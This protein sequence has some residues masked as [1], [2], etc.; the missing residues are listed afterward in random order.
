[1]SPSTRR[2]GGLGALPYTRE[3][4]AA[5]GH[6]AKLEIILPAGELAGALTIAAPPV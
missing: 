1:M 3:N 4:L 6:V 5:N 2:T